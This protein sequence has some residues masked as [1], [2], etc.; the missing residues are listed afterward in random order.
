MIENSRKTLT[1]LSKVE[2]DY[3][4]DEAGNQ[5]VV[6]NVEKSN[7]FLNNKQN[8]LS[9][10]EINSAVLIYSYSQSL[11]NFIIEN[12]NH[13]ALRLFNLKLNSIIGKKV[14]DIIPL[15]RSEKKLE[16]LF[17]VWETG[18]PIQYP[19]TKMI[20]EDESRYIE[21]SN[22]KL[23]TGNILDFIDDLTYKTGSEDELLEHA[24]F[25][26]NSP[27]PTLR[28]SFSGK[29]MLCNPAA[30][31][32]FGKDLIGS[33]LVNIIPGL[34][35]ETFNDIS[36]LKPLQLKEKIGDQTLLFTFVKDLPTQ[37]VYVYTSNISSLI[38]TKEVQKVLFEIT[39][40]VH[41]ADNLNDL[42]KI[43][44][45][46]VG[47]IMETRN[48][49]I[50]QY[51][52]ETDS[53]SIPYF[54][55]EKDSFTKIPA[56]KTLSGYVIKNNVS[57]LLNEDDMEAMTKE[58]LIDLVGSP[59]KKWLGVPMSIDDKVIGAVI[60]QSY[61]DENAFDEKH[62][63]IL[64]FISDQIAISVKRKQ[65]EQSLRESEELFRALIEQ[66][67]DAIFVV[68]HEKIVLVNPAWEKLAG[69][70]FLE[71]T[72]EDFSFFDLIIPEERSKIKKS[73]ILQR[74]L[75]SGQFNYDIDINSK[76][77]K[78]IH[79]EISVSKITFRGK[80]AFQC[81]CRD[82]TERKN[83]IEKVN[84]YNQE[85]K[86][87]NANKDKFFSLIAHDLKSPF[88][89]LLGYSDFILSDYKDLNNKEIYEGTMH[90]NKAARNIYAL[91]ENLLQWSGLQAGGIAFQ[92]SNVLIYNLGKKVVE[93]YQKN[94]E[95]KNILLELSIDKFCEVFA[96]EN[97]LYTVLRNL[98]SNAIKFTNFGGEI[99]I[100][101]EVFDDI[102]NIVISD[103]GLGI[104]ES[105]LD[106]LFR[107]DLSHSTLG[108]NNEK[109]TGLGLLLCKELI[110][111]NK[112]TL[113]V[114]SKE[115]EGSKFIISL[116]ASQ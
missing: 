27:D 36:R 57:L 108:T 66:T 63:N 75:R 6:S 99:E 81:I 18:I 103:N 115:G 107:L 92:P 11:K 13:A 91:L 105:D 68:Q 14:Q 67:S 106:R 24:S 42:F 44:Q 43:I 69:Y 5:S 52:K 100:S 95:A 16:R 40:A 79:V 45:K 88:N 114:S 80:T 78:K 85:L 62:L 37:S 112:G 98:V 82:I 31:D 51:E 17:H 34:S 23:S 1:N 74:R 49:I 86:I 89:A 61:D 29:I 96:D 35:F 41:E 59:S 104:R 65:A 9:I 38:A 116:P 83:A 50:V 87:L 30:V 4:S 46:L 109:G 90:I 58:G 53:L 22:S 32:F 55:D 15:Y 19:L 48:F 60:V 3:L 77:G 20:V 28:V 7:Q 110:E 93:L 8:S 97:M 73:V 94:A 102:V 101:A 111:K 72:N 113:S 64:R 12:A 10:N 84:K 26:M 70:S 39:N 71:A 21:N 47:K 56:G 25:V 54:I 33:S 76:T 2:P